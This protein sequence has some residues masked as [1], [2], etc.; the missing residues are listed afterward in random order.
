MLSV[1]QRV[2]I[3]LSFSIFCLHVQSVDFRNGLEALLVPLSCHTLVSPPVNTL[4]KRL[5]VFFVFWAVTQW[6]DDRLPPIGWQP[7]ISVPLHVTCCIYTLIVSISHIYTFGVICSM[8]Y[9]VYMCCTAR[10]LAIWLAVCLSCWL[11]SSLLC[12]SA[13]PPVLSVFQQSFNAT[14]DYQ[15]SVTFTCITS[16]SPDPEVTWHRYL[17][18]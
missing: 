10:W 8:N 15:E 12:M 14:A 1:P 3:F 18:L 2:L 16:G 13:V 17:R 5:A 9:S 7:L 6:C 4:E 11:F